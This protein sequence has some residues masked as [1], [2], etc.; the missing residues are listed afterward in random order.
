MR[1]ERLMRNEEVIKALFCVIDDLNQQLPKEQRLEKSIETKLYGGE[2]ALDS[3]T[4]ISLIV[5]AEQKI[6][7]E[8][9]VVITL[10]DV[11]AMD[12][13]KN[14]FAT[15]GTLADYISLLLSGESHE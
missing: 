5:G 11:N 8:F 6:E 14:H 15:I 1:E 7:E 3:L 2:N 4:F 13:E 9:G 12:Q 10:A